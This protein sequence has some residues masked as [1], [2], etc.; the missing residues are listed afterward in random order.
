[1]QMV[2][3]KQSASPA[4]PSPRGV[5]RRIGLATRLFG[6]HHKQLSLPRSNGREGYRECI[7]CGARRNF[8]AETWQSAGPFYFPE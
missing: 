3:E 4:D 7:N 8:N 5:K 1:M 2:T 6:C